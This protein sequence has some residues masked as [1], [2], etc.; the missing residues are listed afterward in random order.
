MSP[1]KE[2]EMSHILDILKERG[3]IKQIMGADELR[4]N[5]RGVD[6]LLYWI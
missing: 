6:D 2:I 5:V 4:K 1:S 3:F